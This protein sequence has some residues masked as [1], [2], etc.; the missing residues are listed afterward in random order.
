M[1]ISSNLPAGMEDLGPSEGLAQNHPHLLNAS[2]QP[3]QSG[4]VKAPPV[5]WVRDEELTK[6]NKK[7][8]W[9]PKLDTPLAT[10]YG[11]SRSHKM[12]Y[13]GEREMFIQLFAIHISEY[14][15]GTPC[16]KIADDNMSF[17]YNPEFDKLPT[18]RKE[19][20]PSE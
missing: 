1:G 13:P 19:A 4:G 18:Y 17:V 11:S 20:P 7:P 14:L 2:G 12:F 9:Y 16:V 8:F 6:N 3:M 5:E 15:F 10:E